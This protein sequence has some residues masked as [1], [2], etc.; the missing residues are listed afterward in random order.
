MLATAGIAMNFNG[1]SLF[2]GVFRSP[3]ITSKVDN[4]FPLLRNN[5]KTVEREPHRSEDYHA[6]AWLGVNSIT[7]NLAR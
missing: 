5:I 3:V 2:I 6:I 4:G 7:I 1:A